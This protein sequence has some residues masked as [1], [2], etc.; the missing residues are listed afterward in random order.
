M[1]LNPTTENHAQPFRCNQKVI[2]E[3]RTPEG[4]LDLS[5]PQPPLKVYEVDGRGRGTLSRDLILDDI[6]KMMF[7]ECP[8]A[9]GSWDTLRAWLDSKSWVVRAKT[10]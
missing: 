1:T 8:D 5:D 4:I 3:K 6:Y 9:K 10:W 2:L 7:N